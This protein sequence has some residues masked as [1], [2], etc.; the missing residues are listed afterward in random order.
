MPFHVCS[1]DPSR[2]GETFRVRQETR[3]D[4]FAVAV[5]LLRQG[6]KVVTI[7]D[8]AG[9]VCWR[10]WDELKLTRK[11]RCFGADSKGHGIAVGANLGY[12]MARSTWIPF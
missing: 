8:E 7:I 12:L 10:T 4:A 3:K 1:D 2:P 6:K 11:G 9:R 5:D